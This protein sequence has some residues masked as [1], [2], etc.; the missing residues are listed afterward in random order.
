MRA[1]RLTRQAELLRARARAAA[2]ERVGAIGSRVC[3]P[4]RS[5]LQRLVRSFGSLRSISLF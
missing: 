4:A 5:H 3:T 1:I 2:G